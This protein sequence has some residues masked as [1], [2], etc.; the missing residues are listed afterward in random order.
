MINFYKRTIKDRNIETISSV[1]IGCWINVIDPSPREIS[2]LVKTFKLDRRN[3]ESALDQNEIPRLD[4][5]DDDIY[6]FAKNIPL[7]DKK[8][9][10][11]YLIVI[12][13]KFI[14]TISKSEPNFV[15]DILVGK[16]K[17]I[18]TQKLKCLISLL[19]LINASFEKLTVSVVK[20]VRAEKKSPAE[21]NEKHLYSLLDQED[22]LNG[23][24]SSYY[25]MNLL[26]ERMVR[27]INFFEQ[28]KEI[29]EDLITEG[30]QGF[31]LCKSSLTNISNIRKYYD[32]SLSSKLNRIIT[33]LT[34]F[35]IIISIPAAISGIYG[36]NVFLPFQTKPWAFYLIS[37]VI[38]IICISL[39]WYL[40]KKKI[41]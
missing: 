27:K 23:L 29:I 28:D 11:T 34:I 25:H 6:I 10:E 41:I 22:V 9:I 32:I 17:F 37:G 3:L 14:L 15:K 8:K 33:I 12:T 5:V 30:N 36:M 39:L 18:T 31:N 2:L 16:V 13:K 20:R 7:Q 4:F 19:S 35:T 24:V 21:L 1:M 40:K 26:Y 38:T